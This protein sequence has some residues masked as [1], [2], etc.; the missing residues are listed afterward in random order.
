M[1]NSKS[2]VLKRADRAGDE[3][4]AAL[5]RIVCRLPAEVVVELQPDIDYLINYMACGADVMAQVASMDVD[6]A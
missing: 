2:E 5:A 3:A 1:N 4:A 6:N